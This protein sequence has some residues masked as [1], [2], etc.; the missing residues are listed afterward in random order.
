MWC[1]DRGAFLALM[2]TLGACGFQPL[3]AP[4]TPAVGMLGRIAVDPIEGAEPAFE[5]RERLTERLG[6]ADVADYRLKVTLRLSSRGVA[7]TQQDYTTRYNVTGTATYQLFAA[8]ESSPV[9]SGDVQSFTGFS[10]PESETASAFASRSAEEDAELR[11]ARTL[12]DQIV[13]ELA[14]TSGDWPR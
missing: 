7:L 9:Q 3:Y 8:G 13:M 4:G 14:I 1:F 5:M 10:A 11:L 2:L 6:D 12:A